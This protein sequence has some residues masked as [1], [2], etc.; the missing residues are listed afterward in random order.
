[1]TSLV[2][3]LMVGATFKQAY[4]NH[5]IQA[6]YVSQTINRKQQKQLPST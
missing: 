4:K 1:V 5:L 6:R 3:S 2:L